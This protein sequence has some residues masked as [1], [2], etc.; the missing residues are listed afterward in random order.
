MPDGPDGQATPSPLVLERV[1]ADLRTR[2][3][4]FKTAN[5]YPSSIDLAT[6]LQPQTLLA[7]KHA[8][9]T[10]GDPFGFA[11]RLRTSSKLGFKNPKWNAA[12]EVTNIYRPGYWE[13]RGFNW[14]SGR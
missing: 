1:G 14:F 11:L 9:E 4:A 7:T 3:V 5:D 6:A 10:F 2:Y 13:Q 8:G 12:T